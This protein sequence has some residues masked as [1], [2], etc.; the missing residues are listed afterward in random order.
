MDR[1]QIVIEVADHIEYFQWKWEE[2]CGRVETYADELYRL[3][4]EATEQYEAEWKDV[5]RENWR[6]EQAQPWRNALTRRV[7][8]L[9]RKRREHSRAVEELDQAI[10]QLHPPWREK[11]LP[12]LFDDPNLPADLIKRMEQIKLLW[13]KVEELGK[14]YLKEWR[15]AHHLRKLAD[16]AN[17]TP[18]ARVRAEKPKAGHVLA[19]PTDPQQQWLTA[20]L[21][22]PERRF[23]QRPLDLILLEPFERPVAMIN[24]TA[25]FGLVPNEP[26]EVLSPEDQ[27]LRDAV[28]LVIAHDDAFNDSGSVPRILQRRTYPKNGHFMCDPFVDAL[29]ERL[30]A[31]PLELE[32][33][34]NRLKP[35]K[36]HATLCSIYRKL[37]TWGPGLALDELRTRFE[38]MRD[39]AMPQLKDLRV[40]KDPPSSFSQRERAGRL[41]REIE[42]RVGPVESHL[43]RLDIRL[44]PKVDHLIAAMQDAVNAL[45]GQDASSNLAL[46]NEMESVVADLQTWR[47]DCRQDYLIRNF[48]DLPRLEKRNGVYLAPLLDRIVEIILMGLDEA[49]MKRRATLLDERQKAVRTTLDDLAGDPQAETPQGEDAGVGDQQDYVFGPDFRSGNWYGIECA[50]TPTQAEM[51]SIL[52]DAYESGAPDVDAE[53]LIGKGAFTQERLRAKGKKQS[54]AKRV[55]DVFRYNPAWGTVI[56]PGGTRGTYRLK[57]S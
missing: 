35:I 4:R 24:P 10:L 51:V 3:A 27:T 23:D 21:W 29:A 50:F 12:S 5:Q 15:E 28:V 40:A 41:C 8:N 54:A 44:R 37:H 22:G 18:T 19:E 48:N 53:I 6:K 9:R 55:R 52:V 46:T 57:K 16:P 20:Y 7:R 11:Y 1:E 14:D 34:W 30:R 38:F 2:F 25:W 56:V 36:W 31:K 43:H 26:N 49:N 13:L 33:A 45:R 39:E 17:Y 32:G 47:E 42:T